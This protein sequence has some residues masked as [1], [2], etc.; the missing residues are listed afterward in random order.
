MGSH[1]LSSGCGL[2]MQG[3]THK[4][5]CN[6]PLQSTCQRS[7]HNKAQAQNTVIRHQQP[8]PSPD[9]ALPR[10]TRHR[11]RRTHTINMVVNNTQHSTQPSE[12]GCETR[13]QEE[14]EVP[15]P[16]TNGTT[17]NRN[18]N[19]GACPMHQPSQH[20]ASHN[21]PR[22]VKATQHMQQL[23]V[24]ATRCGRRSAGLQEGWLC[25]PRLGKPCRH[26]D[27][28]A[29]GCYT[30]A[31][32]SRI[33][34]T[35][36]SSSSTEITRMLPK[37]LLFL[38]KSLAL[39]ARMHSIGG[40]LRYCKQGRAGQHSTAATGHSSVYRQVLLSHKQVPYVFSCT[41]S[42]MMCADSRLPQVTDGPRTA[43]DCAPAL[44]RTHRHTR[45][46]MFASPAP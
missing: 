26:I 22:F 41:T 11:H 15:M 21:R 4:N 27:A 33:C 42:A 16:W 35:W 10:Q 38:M 8:C 19:H 3:P 1:I 17:C 32:F 6:T 5:C 28:C 29:C 12:T 13:Y 30:D 39:S 46:C 24:T 20:S 2:Q 18:T 43:R 34:A 37:P 31:S 14:Y 44:P 40:G 45:C 23:K 9:G 36:L 7:C 25:A